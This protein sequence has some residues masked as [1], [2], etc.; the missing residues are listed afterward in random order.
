M[1]RKHFMSFVFIVALALSCLLFRFGSSDI[2]KADSFNPIYTVTNCSNVWSRFSSTADS[3]IVRSTLGLSP[4]QSFNTSCSTGSYISHNGSGYTITEFT[5]ICLSDGN[6]RINCRVLEVSGLF[7]IYDSSNFYS[8]WNK[9]LFAL[10]YA[11]DYQFNYTSA[12]INLYN[13]GNILQASLT[14]SGSDI[15]DVVYEVPVEESSFTN[16]VNS[17]G[18]NYIRLYYSSGI[19]DSS[20]FAPYN[21]I[22]VQLSNY[23][24]NYYNGFIR[25]SNVSLSDFTS[26]SDSYYYWFVLI[27]MT[28]SIVGYNSGVNTQYYYISVPQY[29]SSPVLSYDYGRLEW[30][31]VTGATNYELRSY[32]DGNYYYETTTL[33]TRIITGNGEYSVRA[34][35]SSGE[36]FSSSWSNTIIVDSFPNNEGEYTFLGLFTA[37]ADS[38]IYLIRSMLNYEIWG[39]NFYYAFGVLLFVGLILL[40]LRVF[41]KSSD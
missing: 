11:N 36:Y 5:F 15:T 27:D 21:Y 19:P 6:V 9:V 14:W 31:S 16:V 34:L 23:I 1:C 28:N 38:Q 40:V 32:I 10:N 7:Y 17:L 37:I 35:D 8:Y 3:N 33:L 4:G 20:S 41:R 25:I 18:F 29:L 12:F 24:V 39:I 30:S 26:S 13:S 22:D 2:V